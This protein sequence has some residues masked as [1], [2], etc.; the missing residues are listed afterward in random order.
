MRVNL[1]AQVCHLHYACMNIE[2]VCILYF[3]FTCIGV[4]DALTLLDNED[5]SA[6]IMFLK[7]M[8]ALFDCMNVRNITDHETKR[9]KT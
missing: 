8:D 7:M 1:A 3:P 4:A 9:K 6:T 2:G 5:T